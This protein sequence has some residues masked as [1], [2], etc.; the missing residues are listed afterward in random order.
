[1]KGC[2]R[3][4]KEIESKDRIIVGQNE[5]KSSDTTKIQTLKV[6][7]EVEAKQ[8]RNLLEIKN[9]DG[10]KVKRYCAALKEAAMERKMIPATCD[11]VK[12]YATVGE[13]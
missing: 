7:P 11:A 3:Y 13:I 6:D 12:A 2:Y 10:S 4:Q 9:R 5:Y 8:I 1:L